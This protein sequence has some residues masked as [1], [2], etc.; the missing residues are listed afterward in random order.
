MKLHL[1]ADLGSGWDWAME[2]LIL[3][4]ICS[5]N[6]TQD[7]PV[8]CV[9]WRSAIVSMAGDVF[10]TVVVENSSRGMFSR[11]RK[12]MPRNRDVLFDVL[13]ELVQ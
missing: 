13:F 2:K 9:P 3:Y 6:F 12:E 5:R 10:H 11:K 7:H 8:W 4:L 1:D